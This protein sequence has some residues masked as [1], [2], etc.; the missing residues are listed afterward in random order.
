M[1]G[2]IIVCGDDALALRIIDELN[3]A[4]MTVVQLQ[5]PTGLSMAGV[6]T[7]AAVICASSDDALNLELA[8]LARQANPRLRVVSRLA[9]TVLKSALADTNGPGAVLDVADLAAPSV[10]EALL[11]RTAHSITVAGTDF[12]VSGDTAPR[13]G[14]FRELYGHLVPVAILRGGSSPN[15]GEVIPCPNR[16]IE[17]YPGDSTTMIGTG[18][19]LAAEGVHLPKPMATAMKHRS[20]PIRIVDSI[21]ALHHDV[22][23]MFYKSLAV[24]AT[25]VVVSTIVLRFNFRHHEPFT[26][27]DALYF[28]AATITTTGY[29]DFNFSD[30]PTWLRIWGVIMMMVG[31]AASAFVIGFA[32]D[33]LLS[34]RLMKSAG[35]QKASHLR[36]HH[37]IVGLGS[38]GTRVAGM[39]RNAGHAVAVIEL[40]EDNRYLSAARELGVPVIFGDA[41]MRDTLEAAQLPRARAIAVLTE[42]DMTN[43]ETAIVA[44]EML[45]PDQTPNQHRV[46]VV[47]RI[48]DRALGRAVGQRLGFN[49]VRSTV[50]LATPWFMGAAMGLEVLG[51]FS[52]GQ[53]SFMIGGG[54]VEPGSEL[55]GMRL[56]EISGHTR[57]IAIGHTGNGQP[58]TGRTSTGLSLHPKKDTRLAAGDTIYLVGPF[59]ELLAILRKGQ[60]PARSGRRTSE[61]VRPSVF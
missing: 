46:P 42:D 49:F 29:G 1:L 39:L 15:P 6:D 19:E 5:S 8:L 24:A 4:E 11:G 20:M 47:M 17:I 22:N 54:E 23:P 41:T 18:P 21:R 13:A 7:A 51:T 25:L 27:V 43:I 36:R 34:R 53:R 26:W 60:R 55:D 50:D 58:G 52:V 16:D 40:N 61:P 37:V 9:N 12:T 44:R 48:Y 3:D 10:V 30:Q 38:F 32:T 57:V 59:R 2:H 14:T 56:I 31:W 35:L 33:V 45:G 28:T